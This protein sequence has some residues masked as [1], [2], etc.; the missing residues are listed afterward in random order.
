[1]GFAGAARVAPTTRNNQPTRIAERRRRRGVAEKF[2]A[3]VGTVRLGSI[4]GPE[5]R[6]KEYRTR[7][8][9]KRCIVEVDRL[10]YPCQGGQKGNPG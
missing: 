7:Q 4:R 1:M 3:I 5:Q 9:K 10:H 2:S 6:R 8:C